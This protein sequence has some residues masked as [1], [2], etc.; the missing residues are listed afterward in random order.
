MPGAYTD[1]HGCT[2]SASF[3]SFISHTNF[4]FGHANT[5]NIQGRGSGKL[6]SSLVVLTLLQTIIKFFCPPVY[7]TSPAA[8]VNVSALYWWGE[9]SRCN[10]LLARKK[11]KSSFGDSYL[12]GSFHYLDIY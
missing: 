9:F 8:A 3:Q 6:S 4:S 2:F 11:K 12:R 1:L 10:Q 5:R 7:K